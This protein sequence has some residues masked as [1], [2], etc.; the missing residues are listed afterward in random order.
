M[1]TYARKTRGYGWLPDIPNHHDTY[2]RG[3]EPHLLDNLPASVDLSPSM[4]PEL[5]FDQGQIGSCVPNASIAAL[6]YLQQK[7]QETVT[8]LSRLF[9]YYI[10]R[11]KEGTVKSDAGARISDMVALLHT[12]GSCPESEWPYNTSLYQK[13]PLKSCYKD[14]IKYESLTSQRVDQTLPAFQSCLASG[15]PILIGITVYP[16]FESPEVE[17]TGIVPMPGQYE[18]PLGGHCMLVCGYDNAT[19]RF[20]T[21]NSW[22]SGFGDK[23]YV[24]LPYGYILS[25]RYGGDYWTIQTVK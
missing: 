16:S 8:V 4:P 6:M 7:Q 1:T 13:R 19:Q 20:K 2:Y 10:V 14:A 23:G 15:Y 25:T 21:L 11:A 3:L 17:S 5:P 22:G 12:L 9:A 18:A 24:H